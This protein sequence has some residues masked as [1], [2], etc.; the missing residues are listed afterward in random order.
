MNKTYIIFR[1]KLRDIVISTLGHIKKP[2]PFVHILNGHRIHPDHMTDADGKYFADMLEELHNHCDFINF[3]D[4][5]HKIA[6]HTP[7]DRPQIA[8]SFD[9]G[10]LDCYEQIAP[11]LEKYGVNAMFFINPNFVDAGQNNDEEYIKMFTTTKMKCNGKR[12]LNWELVKDLQ[13]RGFLIGAHTMDHYMINNGSIEELQHQICDCKSIIEEH[14]GVPCE[15]FAF[16]YGKLSQ[17]NQASIDIAC[18]TYKYVFSQSD[19]KHF[20]SFGG[21]VIN[22]RHFEPFWPVSHVKY[23]ISCKR[24]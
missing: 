18:N 14:I 12:P 24:T 5:I 3:E 22:R 9:D 11:T 23:F 15:Y 10:F 4:A 13:K 8:F 6:T 17:A 20:F 16:P 21:K 7:V 1:S 19:H 2:T